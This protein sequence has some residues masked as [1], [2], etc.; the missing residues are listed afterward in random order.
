MNAPRLRA[1]NSVDDLRESFDRMFAE[2][3]R[4]DAASSD[5]DLLA[6]TIE[7][8]SYA[9]RLSELSGLYPDKKIER[10]PASV[11]ALVGL[12]GLGT[13]LLAVYDLGAL[14]G[15]PRASASRWLAVIA[16]AQVAVSFQQFDGFLR[17]PRKAI[18]Q[19]AFAGGAGRTQL[20]REVAHNDGVVTPIIHLPSVVESIA[21]LVHHAGRPKE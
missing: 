14:L 7:E 20:V 3:P 1:M 21:V 11:P 6:I 18:T 8:H 13:T 17:L 16:G 15:Y 10:L 9:L 19:A 4:F 12:V 5:D 2:A